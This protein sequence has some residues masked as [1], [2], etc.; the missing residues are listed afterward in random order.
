MVFE[1]KG[2][3]SREERQVRRLLRRLAGISSKEEKMKYL[4][5]CEAQANNYG[6]L[7][8][9]LEVEIQMKPRWSWMTHV[10]AFCDRPSS[11]VMWS[12]RMDAWS[13]VLPIKENDANNN[14]NLIRFEIMFNGP[15]THR[16]TWRLSYQKFHASRFVCCFLHVRL[17]GLRPHRKGWM[18]ET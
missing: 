15:T 17:Q 18:G 10:T 1:R 9:N 7:I 11:T 12:K 8:H 13:T 14:A 3:W 4:S 6:D 16:R 2:Y 5:D